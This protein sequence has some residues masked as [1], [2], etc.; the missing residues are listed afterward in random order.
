MIEKA[1]WTYRECVTRRWPGTCTL[2]PKCNCDSRNCH[3]VF[4]APLSK[5]RYGSAATALKV[6]CG[7]PTPRRLGTRMRHATRSVRHWNASSLNHYYRDLLFG[8]TTEVTAFK[9]LPAFY[10]R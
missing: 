10:A 5:R 3:L 6:C 9:P 7:Q 2:A 1:A 4:T 8:S